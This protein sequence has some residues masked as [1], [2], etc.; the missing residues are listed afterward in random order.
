MQ[1]DQVMVD[2]RNNAKTIA[3]RKYPIEIV[4]VS[5][6]EEAFRGLFS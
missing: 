1:R 5:V 6:I 3:D 2:F 4:A